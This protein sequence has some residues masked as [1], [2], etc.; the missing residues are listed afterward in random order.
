MAAFDLD[1]FIKQSS[2]EKLT[3]CRKDDLFVIAQHYEILPQASSS[4]LDSPPLPMN[5]EEPMHLGRA[6]LSQAERE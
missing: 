1:D 5:F 6:R 3:N 4:A 2:I